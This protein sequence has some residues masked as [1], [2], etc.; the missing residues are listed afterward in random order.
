MLPQ[1]IHSSYPNVRLSFGR[2]FPARALHMPTRLQHTESM[3]MRNEERERGKNG[4][5]NENRFECLAKM[6][7]MEKRTNIGNRLDSHNIWLSLRSRVELV[8]SINVKIVDR[9]TPKTTPSLVRH[10][11]LSFAFSLR[12]TTSLAAVYSMLHS[13]TREEKEWTRRHEKINKLTDNDNEA[14]FPFTE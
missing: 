9:T 4:R 13:H 11:V 6:K 7:T 2:I 3:M 1:S 8:G 14:D 5:K 12:C 10:V